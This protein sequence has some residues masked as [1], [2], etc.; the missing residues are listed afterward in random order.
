MF[1][2]VCATVD[3]TVPFIGIKG[4]YFTVNGLFFQRTAPY[5]TRCRERDIC[6]FFVKT[7]EA[8]YSRGV[9]LPCQQ[10]RCE[11]SRKMTRFWPKC[12]YSTYTGTVT[13]SCHPPALTSSLLKDFFTLA[14]L[15]S[16][17]CS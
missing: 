1:V 6:A 8:L 12:I 15:T 16:W 2:C 10:N 14:L 4:K 5:D 9:F 11:N 17:L 7:E 13:C 3:S